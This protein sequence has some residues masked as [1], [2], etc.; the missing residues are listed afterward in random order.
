[1]EQQKATNALDKYTKKERLLFDRELIKMTTRFG[2]LK[3]L[4]R[5]PDLI[6]VASV[7]E[8][9]L[10][11]HEAKVMGV[12]VMGITNTD[13]DPRT[14]ALSIPANDR[15]KVSVDLIIDYFTQALATSSKVS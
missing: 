12:K 6:F 10:A 14:I 5:M 7:K 4:T 11:V 13:A 3:K 9:Q 8:G 15:S 1:M 2:G